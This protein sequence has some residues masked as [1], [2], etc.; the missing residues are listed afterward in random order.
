MSQAQ[1]TT[2]LSGPEASTIRGHDTNVPE[3]GEGA[4]IAR[5]ENFLCGRRGCNR[6]ISN[7]RKNKIF[8]ND[9][10]RWKARDDELRRRRDL[11][12]EALVEE[13]A[14]PGCRDALLEAVRG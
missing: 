4:Q 9:K 10:C 13:H 8:C 11:N 5:I 14:C 1:H 12:F 2:P 7:G 3:S 6:R